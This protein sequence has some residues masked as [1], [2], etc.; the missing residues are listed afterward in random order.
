[1]R[2]TRDAPFPDAVASSAHRVHNL[3]RERA[4]VGCV[5][6]A[7][8]SSAGEALPA[9]FRP[10]PELDEGWREVRPGFRLAEMRARGEAF[11]ARFAADGPVAAVRT[12]DLLPFPYLVE[13]AFWHAAPTRAKYLLLRN[14]CLLIEF[15]DW[16][17]APRTLLVNPTEADLSAKAGFFEQVRRELVPF[18]PREVLARVPGPAQRLRRQLGVDP[19]KIDYITFDHLHVQDLRRGLVGEG[20]KPPLYPRAR[21]IV[22][23]RE[24]ETLR[25]LHPLQRPWWIPEALH[26]VPAE[27]IVAVEGSVWLGPGLAL[28]WTPG[29][30]L[31]NHSIVFHAAGRGVF[32]V[33]ENGVCPESYEPRMSGLRS[34]REYAAKYGAEVVL[35]GNALESSM[36]QY[37][38]MVLEKAIV[39]R[40]DAGG[41]IPNIYC[42]SP[43]IR[44]PL[45]WGI[46]PRYTIAP[47]D[48]GA[49][50]HCLA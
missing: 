26:G 28:V 12:I 2:K 16:S 29:H 15:V 10:I 4:I 40:G 34:L 1:M 3:A 25:A 19:A 24:V 14:R 48:V 23:R 49:L 22:N 37:T 46:G 35:N 9:G 45:A 21:L 47:I 32:A 50:S 11:A 20:K 44:S 41:E 7:T 27:R 5:S 36:S 33:S 42:S 30:T 6:E 39:G 17:G 8:T 38:S 43:L 13:F 31:G 18:V